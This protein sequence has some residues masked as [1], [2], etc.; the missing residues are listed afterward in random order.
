MMTPDTPDDT[1][2]LVIHNGQISPGCLTAGAVLDGSSRWEQSWSPPPTLSQRADFPPIDPPT[3]TRNPWSSLH[4]GSLILFE[5]DKRKLASQLTVPEGFESLERILAFPTKRYVG[6][7][8]GSFGGDND[9]GVEAYTIAFVSKSLPPGSRPER[10]WFAIPIARTKTE[11]GDVNGRKPLCPKPFPWPGCYQYTVFETRVV[12][13]GIYPSAIEYGLDENDFD[14]FDAFSFEDRATLA[15]QRYSASSV[16]DEKEALLVESMR[17]LGSADPL[18]V[19]VWQE[20]T[21]AG[22][23]HDPRDFVEEVFNLEEVI[24]IG[25]SS[26]RI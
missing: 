19:K 22:E 11:T 25:G 12:P 13:T 14:A 1:K 4:P 7:V 20:L 8:V 26:K 23:C 24:K 18:P 10:N 21:A 5:L 17:M 15:C 16:S 3:R 6:L 2:V 9:S